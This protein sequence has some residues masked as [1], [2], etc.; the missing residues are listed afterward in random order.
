VLYLA[1]IQ[2]KSGG[3]LSSNKVGLKLLAQQR[4]EDRWQVLANGEVLTSDKVGDFSP[5]V[6]VLVDVSDKS[7]QVQ[8]VK[9]ST[10]T[11][12]NNFQNISR[13]QDRLKDQ[14]EEIEQWKQSLTYQS[15]E[16]NRREEVEM[17]SRRDQMHQIESEM[18]RLEQEKQES[19]RL[20]EEAQ[21]L[22]TELD[23]R[24]KE[25]KKAW[26]Q[27]R[28]EQ[29]ELAVR[30]ESMGE[31]AGLSTEQLSQLQ[32]RIHQLL[33]AVISGDGVK[34]QLHHAL[35]SLG[36]Q[37][38]LVSQHWEQWEQHQANATQS[39]DAV[40]QL[41]Q[42]VNDRWQTWEQGQ[43]A[44]ERA[45]AALESLQS[46]VAS[47]QDHAQTLQNQIAAQDHL[48]QQLSSALGGVD[49]A[50]A[51][52]VDMAAL[53]QMP[54]N[55]LETLV[56]ELGKDYQKTFNFV[57]DQEEELRFLSQDIDTK[58]AEIAKAS[59]FDS[60]TLENELAD[61]NSEYQLFDESVLPQRRRLREAQ[62]ILSAHQSVLSKRKGVPITEDSK[63]ELD[64]TPVLEQIE[65]HRQTDAA[66]LATLLDKIEQLQGQMQTQARE[67][68][69]QE[70]QQQQ[71]RQDIETLEADL[72][73]Q[74]ANLGQVWG[75]I[76]TYQELLQPTNETLNALEQQ[77]Q[78]LQQEVDSL[79]ET[80]SHQAQ[81]LAEM[82]QS[83]AA[84]AA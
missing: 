24:D 37:R 18:A 61:L 11:I 52:Q 32:E 8:R 16:L 57:N 67:V 49:P 59:E 33:A 40:S 47:Q 43:S 30:S 68:T 53:E 72:R 55:E 1:E 31:A 23:N 35:E 12:L 17:E 10:R 76:N 58:K 46:L 45:K 42:T 9:E 6:L 83:L 60:L 2:K 64:L 78:V 73:Q 22:R 56:Q 38:S 48:H 5:G 54:I 28:V 79:Q 3:L 65:A 14:E 51:Q 63:L 82:N 44:L 25:L 70:A 71:Q 74:Q 41:E 69:E 15:Q 36:H 27:L 20:R 77:L 62:A 66:A 26:N 80:G 4:S 50:A 84:L 34:N 81:L 13:F 39:Q 21:H 75:K 7:G 19:N 29:Q